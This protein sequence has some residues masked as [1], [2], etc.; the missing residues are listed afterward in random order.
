[1]YLWLIMT[2]HVYTALPGLTGPIYLQQHDSLYHLQACK[3]CVQQIITNFFCN[4]QRLAIMLKLF[5]CRTNT[6]T[7][8]GLPL[9]VQIFIKP[10]I[11]RVSIGKTSFD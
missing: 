3:L 7:L 11:D 5:Y 10:E 6:L 4:Y 9:Y 1:M 2:I 8:T